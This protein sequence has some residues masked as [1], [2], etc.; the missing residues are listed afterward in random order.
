MNI[1]LKNNLHFANKTDMVLIKL[2]VL[3]F[4]GTESQTME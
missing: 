4:Q 3:C 2:H 1:I